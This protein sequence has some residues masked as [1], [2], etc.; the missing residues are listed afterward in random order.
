MYSI[1]KLT[2]SLHP[3][4]MEEVWDKIMEKDGKDRGLMVE[5]AVNV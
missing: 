2:E 1:R 5:L 3:I 4:S